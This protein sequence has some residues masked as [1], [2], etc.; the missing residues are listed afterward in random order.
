MLPVATGCGRGGAAN[1]PKPVERNEATT[2]TARR[3]EVAFAMLDVAWVESRARVAHLCVGRR[4]GHRR[5]A[6]RV[7]QTSRR[8]DD[9]PAGT[10]TLLFPPSHQPRPLADPRASALRARNRARARRRTVGG[11]WR[12][13]WL[14]DRSDWR[15]TGRCKVAIRQRERTW[16]ARG[17]EAP[18]AQAGERASVWWVCVCGV[19]FAGGRRIARRKTQDAR[20]WAC[21][22]GSQPAG[23]ALWV[24]T[25][26]ADTFT[27]TNN[28]TTSTTTTRLDRPAPWR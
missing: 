22:R 12:Q 7:T 26:T 9:G 6:E 27:T 3:R 1:V 4:V 21:G 16:A 17:A 2:R 11:R 19:R 13:V 18:H 20:R 8:R 24:T 25:P 23:I 14:K 15:C 5:R 10:A 28:P